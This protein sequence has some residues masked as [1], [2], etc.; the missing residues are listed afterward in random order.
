MSWRK[1][2]LTFFSSQIE[3]EDDYYKALRASKDPNDPR[4]K[5][6]RA[7]KDPND[8]RTK[9]LR[10]SKDPNDPRTKGTKGPRVYKPTQEAS[11]PAAKK[12]T[13]QNIQR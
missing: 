8:P 11:K 3:T 2:V 7:S 5:A 13:L 6:F 4:T 9:A 10:A 1:I 12:P